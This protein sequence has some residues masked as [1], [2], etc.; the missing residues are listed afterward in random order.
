MDFL[1]IAE[2]LWDS[3]IISLITEVEEPMFSY[4]Y[5]RSPTSPSEK[6]FN[7]FLI[8]DFLILALSIVASNLGFVPIKRI[9]SDSSILLI[10]ELKI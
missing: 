6:I 8:Y 4:G 3:F 7:L 2:I 9:K 5:V 10:D 1:I